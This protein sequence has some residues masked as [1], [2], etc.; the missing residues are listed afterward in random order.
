MERLSHLQSALYGDPMPKSPPAMAE[1]GR[2]LGR[3]LPPALQQR[4]QLGAEPSPLPDVDVLTEAVHVLHSLYHSLTT[5]VP[6]CLVERVEACPSPG[7]AQGRFLD[8]TVLF[9]DI[10]GFTSLAE[11]L[12]QQGPAGI[13]ELTAIVNRYFGEM[14]DVLARSGGDVLK[15]AGDAV[16]VY[17]PALARERGTEADWAIRAGLR[18]QQAMAS[19]Q[20]VETS[21]GAFELRMKVGLAS[22]RFLAAQVGTVQRMEFIVIG[23]AIQTVMVAEGLAESGQVVIAPTTSQ[24]ASPQTRRAPL[25]DGFATVDADQPSPLGDF[26]IAA[27]GRRRGAFLPAREAPALWLQIEQ[28]LARLEALAPYLAP[29]LVARLVAGGKR[30]RVE[31]EYR[32]TTVLFGHFVGPEHY[33]AALQGRED[34]A[35]ALATVLDLYFTRVQRIVADHGGIVSRIDPYRQGSKLLVLFGAPVAHEDDPARALDAALAIRAELPAIDAMARSIL[36]RYG[37]ETPADEPVFR[38]RAGITQGRTFAGEAGTRNRREYTVMGDEVNLAARL[39]AASEYGQILLSRRVQECV[40]PRFLLRPLDPI[41]VKG[42]SKPIPIYE[43]QGRRVSPGDVGSPVPLCGRDEELAVAQQALDDAASG[44]GRTRSVVLVGEAGVGKTRLAAE[45]GAR[46]SARGFRV[47]W[48]TVRGYGEAPPYDLWR[49]IL[50]SLLQVPPG[51]PLADLEDRLRT[52]GLEDPDARLAL[53]DVLGISLSPVAAVAP[54]TSA[55]PGRVFQPAGLAVAPQTPRTT[56][57]LWT[58]ADQR[59]QQKSQAGLTVLDD[60]VSAHRAQRVRRGV[61]ALLERCASQTP[62]LLVF[63]NAQGMAD[64]SWEL[65]TDLA[66]QLAGWPIL[67][68]VLVRPG[69]AGVEDRV[70]GLERAGLAHVLHLHNLDPAGTIALAQSLLGRADLPGPVADL[71]YARSQGN[72]LFVAELLYALREQGYLA[73]DPAGGPLQV[74]RDPRL[75]ELPTTVSGV[76]LSRFDRLSPPAQRILQA[77]A[78]I[79]REFRYDVLQGLLTPSMSRLDLEEGLAALIQAQFIVQ[80]EAVPRSF[81]FLQGV[82][83]EAIYESLSLVERRSLHR[84]V[85]ECLETM[86]V[87][88]LQAHCQELA[89]HFDRGGVPD[90]AAAYLRMTSGKAGEWKE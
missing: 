15:F 27:L 26:E 70:Q 47:L 54:A 36:A 71:I 79:G 65:L 66:P 46:A 22:G 73:V 43:A 58:L 74:Q 68:V 81:A 1:L 31:S 82:T 18:M 29:E 34:G 49:E 14:L 17:F 24:R 84:A 61:A 55:D 7:Q 8:G 87:A 53:A 67:A 33:F 75:V 86:F 5:Y 42:K 60:R 59:I 6:R 4:L 78:V 76:I 16:L 19:F 56:R 80:R 40:G 3:F 12:G 50:A 57:N 38:Q 10:S 9:A 32:A 30:R 44:R 72:P 64:T 23:P 48:G 69:A 63:E 39:M 51:A 45:I 85:G 52:L 20:T 37:V 41:R 90:K 21:Q 2:R 13:E 83:Q 11:R 77:A 25:R 88:D 89:A 35:Q 28:E 62:L